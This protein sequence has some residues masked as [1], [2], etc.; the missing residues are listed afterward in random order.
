[1]GLKS[2]QTWTQARLKFWLQMFPFNRSAKRPE[3][4]MPHACVLHR[5]YWFEIMIISLIMSW[6][7]GHCGFIALTLC[8]SSG[9]WPG[10]SWPVRHSGVLGSH[11]GTDSL[12]IITICFEGRAESLCRQ[13]YIPGSGRQLDVTLIVPPQMCW[14]PLYP[15]T[16]VN[17]MMKRGSKRF[18]GLLQHWRLW[19]PNWS[20]SKRESITGE[21]WVGVV[22]IGLDK[23]WL[24]GSDKEKPI[25]RHKSWTQP[26]TAAATS[27]HHQTPI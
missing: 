19:V 22:G 4:G 15:D 21:E 24:C 27:L 8:R 26:S 18:S 6:S 17:N 2:L 10:W 16:G 5:V 13:Q 23:D 1:M 11:S 9:W 12:S 3:W 14:I 25:C 7:T 20:R